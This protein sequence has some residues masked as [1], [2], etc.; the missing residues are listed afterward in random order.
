MMVN[1]RLTHVLSI[2]SLENF[3]DFIVLTFSF[4]Q[5]SYAVSEDVGNATLNVSLSGNLGMLVASV[6]LAT[7]DTSTLASARGKLL[8]GGGALHAA[9]VVPPPKFSSLFFSMK[10]EVTT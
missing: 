6:S 10:L 1:Q 7:D 3:F 8:R 5:S 4:S 2:F 9:P